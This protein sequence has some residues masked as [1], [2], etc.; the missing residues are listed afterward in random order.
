MTIFSRLILLITVIPNLVIGQT[1]AN[2][3]LLTG[4]TNIIWE[5]EIKLGTHNIPLS[6]KGIFNYRLP[7]SRAASYALSHQN[8][9]VELFL[10]PGDS[11]NINFTE[12]DIVISGTSE[13]LNNSLQEYSRNVLK[14]SSYL[15][16]YNEMV[17][18]LPLTRFNEKIDSL[19]KTDEKN[20]EQFLKENENLDSSLKNKLQNEITYRTK[21]YKLLYPHNYNRHTHKLAQV[22]ANYFINITKGSFNHPELLSSSTFVRYVNLYLDIQSL[23]KYKFRNMSSSPVERLNSRYQAILNLPVAQQVKDF[24][25][26]QHF[27]KAFGNYSAKDLSKSFHLFENDCKS[28]SIK[29]EVASLYKKSIAQRKVPSEIRIYKQV[30][31]I[32]LEAHIFYPEAF[33]KADH[34]AAYIFFHGGSWATGMPEWGYD[35]CRRYV[36]K[37]MVA[38]SIEYRLQDV[39]AAYI[40]DAVAD[41]LSA[42]AWVRQHSVELGINPGRIVVAGF[43]S[44]AHLAACTAMISKTNRA[45]YFGD[46][47]TFN[48][49]PN[50]VILQ[51]AAYTVENR[52][53]TSKAIP[54]DSY[55]PMANV[56]GDLPVML[57][58][59][60]EFDEIVK[61]PEFEQFVE[62][63]KN[64]NNKFVH[65]SFKNGHFFYNPDIIEMVNKIS[66]EFLA[67][68][69]F[70]KND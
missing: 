11:L 62:K 22:R 59:H 52:G 8:R 24:F 55:S 60:G 10:S 54:V 9:N 35:N 66:D 49:V 26:N 23:G 1:K 64:T 28:E 63:M 3:A 67:T 65:T 31:D 12:Q 18:S 21:F 39:H 4:K 50:A 38:I 69:G 40:S 61:Y 57:I 19:K 42:I 29:N 2:Y 13:K 47:T 53:A 68:Y 41:A 33:N 16:N 48:S 70:T 44:G 32:E 25:F 43:S 34:R 36:G 20:F 6:E 5:R 46:D 58:M 56:K 51:S 15:D 45:K 37:G 17:F 14:N 30:G 27:Q 7:L